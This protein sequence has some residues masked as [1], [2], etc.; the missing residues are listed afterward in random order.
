MVGE[1]DE[2]TPACA[3]KMKHAL[4]QARL[5]LVLNASQMPFYENPAGYYPVLLDFLASASGA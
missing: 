2:L 3:M 4:P 5:N 1:R